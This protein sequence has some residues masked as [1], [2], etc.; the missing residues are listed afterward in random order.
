MEFILLAAS[1]GFGLVLG[2][3]LNVLVSRFPL[4]AKGGGI[5][6]YPD[7]SDR[8]LGRNDF[9]R[10]LYRKVYRFLMRF[11]ASVGVF[12]GRSRCD[13]CGKVLVWYELIPVLSF[14][15]L[16]GRCSVCA[17]P[18]PFRYSVIEAIMGGAFLGIMQRFLFSDMVNG[19]MTHDIASSSG[20]LYLHAGAVFIGVFCLIGIFAFDAAY[21]I[22]PDSLTGILFFAGIVESAIKIT[23]L[24]IESISSV[25]SAAAGISVFFFALWFFTEGKGMGFGDVKLSV[26]LP[27]FVGSLEGIASVFLA[28]WIGAAVSLGLIAA[29]RKKSKDQIAFGPFLAAGA[30]A[31]LLYPEMGLWIFRPLSQIV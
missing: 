13:H 28:F 3:F 25:A 31:V 16:R 26:V 21:R 19:I 12:W 10:L 6:V 22:I 24:G 27:V 11:F 7:K 20:I 4:L 14:L 23:F 29:G 30:L 15:V 17:Q 18:I 5:S 8:Q 9:F 2:S 1:L